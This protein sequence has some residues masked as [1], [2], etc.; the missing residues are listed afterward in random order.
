M[1]QF[2]W[3]GAIS[4]LPLARTT[5]FVIPAVPIASFIF[6]IIFL[7]ERPT[8]REIIGVTLVVI[9]VLT[10]VTGTGARADVNY[11]E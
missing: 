4:R 1:D 11:H 7:G 8:H 5:A 3:Y 9:G 10:L 6:A 2:T